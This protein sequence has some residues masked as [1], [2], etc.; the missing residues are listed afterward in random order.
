M[1][2][3]LLTLY[4]DRY[5]LDTSLLQEVLRVAHMARAMHIAHHMDEELEVD[6]NQRVAH[7]LVLTLLHLLD[8][9][10]DLCHSIARNLTT[11]AYGHKIFV[12]TIHMPMGNLL[13]WRAVAPIVLPR[14]VVRKREL[15]VLL[16]L[17]LCLRGEMFLG[18]ICHCVV[19]PSS[20][21]HCTLYTK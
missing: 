12:D 1:V 11:R 8:D 9:A 13:E 7:L 21:R 15:K 4:I 6:C 17:R 14:R 19:S 5:T 3:V 16:A 20:P 2:V 18:N 10:V